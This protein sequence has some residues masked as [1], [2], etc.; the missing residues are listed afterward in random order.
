MVTRLD[1]AKQPDHAK[2]RQRSPNYPV[3][4][5]REAVDLARKLHDADGQAGAPREAVVRRLGYTSESGRCR[6]VI[7]A[8]RKYGLIEDR[9]GKIVVAR[10][11]V[12]IL[13]F[14]P[15]HPRHI[16][17]LRGGALGPDIYATLV[18]KYRKVGQLPSDASLKPELVADYGFHRN[19]VDTLL[20]NFR[21]SLEHAGLIEGNRLLIRDQEQAGDLA[22]QVTPDSGAESDD[23]TSAFETKQDR[24]VSHGVGQFGLPPMQPNGSP[25]LTLLVDFAEG[26]PVHAHIWFDKP[27]E[28]RFLRR[29]GRQLELMEQGLTESLDESAD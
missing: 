21:S 25:A 18:S 19:A 9:G 3:I 13:M 4:D 17:A 1:H 5:L 8:L 22:E 20:K 2:S 7:S 16:Q 11:A 27:L 6:G 12:D 23:R 14:A 26:Q 29:L 10:R 15:D 28:R 24:T